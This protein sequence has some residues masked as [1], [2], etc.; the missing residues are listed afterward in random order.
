[1][2]F[3]TA[4]P[5]NCGDTLLLLLSL[6]LHLQL[7]QP[8]RPSSE[9]VAGVDSHR[10]VLLCSCAGTPCVS[11]ARALQHISRPLLSRLL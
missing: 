5:C 3:E 1:M 10:T 8:S 4:A 11:T 7:Q 9:L 6:F 2:S